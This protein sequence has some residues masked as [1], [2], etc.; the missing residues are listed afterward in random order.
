MK[1]AILS[2]STADEA[3]VR[4]FVEALLNQ[5]VEQ[6]GFTLRGRGWPSV[7]DTLP[8]VLRQLYYRTDAEALVLVVDSD[9]SPLH[10]AAHEAP[11]GADSDCRLC[12]LLALVERTQR[13]LNT[14]PG[15]AQ[16][17]TAIG[18]AVPAI[19]AWYLCDKDHRGAEATWLQ[20]S[21]P[22]RGRDVRK[23]LKQAVYGTDR[24]SI[25]LETKCAVNEA[26]RLAQD[27]TRLEQFFPGGFGTLAR[28]IRG[29]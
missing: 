9:D 25:D 6:I 26:R 28:S 18:L 13:S 23:Q 2:E 15:R 27:L 10:Q 1:V 16:I 7:R 17:K 19:E 8:A 20:R 4:I 11:A 24:P 22:T 12:N 3:A 14:L 21:S 29:W 5:P